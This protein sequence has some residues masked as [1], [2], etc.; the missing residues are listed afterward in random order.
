MRPE[1]SWLKS[2]KSLIFSSLVDFLIFNILFAITF[3]E[4]IL[5]KSIFYFLSTSN[6][7]IWI[8]L[9][10]IVGRYGLIISNKINLFL[11]NSI[12]SSLTIFFSLF[13]C[14]KR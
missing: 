12:Q 4:Y 1:L 14:H 7:L 8:I 2:R 5:N 3:K 6:S 13:L 10:Y 9:S 11:R